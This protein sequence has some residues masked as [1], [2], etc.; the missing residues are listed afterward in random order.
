MADG[1]YSGLV[2][3]TV[4]LRFC[5]KDAEQTPH[6]HAEELVRRLQRRFPAM[7]V[8]REKGNAYVQEGLEKLITLQAPDVILQSH[9]SYF[10]NTIYVSIS[11]ERW[12]GARAIAYLQS[13]YPPLGD[14]VHFDVID[15]TGVTIIDT[16]AQEIKGAMEMV[17]CSELQ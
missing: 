7:I 10:E 12:N 2:S 17:L 11:E 8:D 13:I 14:R 1:V 16:I 9:R 6:M 4:E 5:L 3:E 15:A